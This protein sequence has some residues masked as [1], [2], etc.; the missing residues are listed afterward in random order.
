M[1]PVQLQSSLMM[2]GFGASQPLKQL[3]QLYSEP[4]RAMVQWEFVN[5][6]CFIYFS[7][8]CK[9]CRILLWNAKE[10]LL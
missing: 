8:P 9:Q 2:L 7:R 4:T 10:T 1:S 3:K 6:A 5:N